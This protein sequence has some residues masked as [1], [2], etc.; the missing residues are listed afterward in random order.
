MASSPYINRFLS[1][2][3]VVPGAGNPQA[4]NRYSYVLNNPLRYTDPTGHYC[5]GDDEDC[6][7]E[8]G[9]GPAPSGTGGS[10]GNGGNGGGGNPHDDDDY[11]PNPNGLA[12]PPACYPGELVCQLQEDGYSPINVTINWNAVVD[13][14]AWEHIVG[15]TLLGVVTIGI[16]GVMI[17]AGGSVCTTV[18]GCIAGAP[19]IA[20]G[21]LA[22]PV[23]ATLMY[24]GFKFMQV[25]L[26]EVFEVTP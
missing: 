25:Y 1:A 8:A 12:A 16:G 2:D 5:V 23:G 15:A 21:V 18:V 9:N 6:A 26:D 3:T 19:L 13:P 4:W 17:E 24:S 14:L 22:V 10:N 20:A 7:D 11:D